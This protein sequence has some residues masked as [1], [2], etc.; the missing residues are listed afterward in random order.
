[1]KPRNLLILL[2]VV[3]ALAAFLWF[4]E[5][6]LPGS[7]E[8][9]EMA[10]RVLPG[11]ETGEVTALAVEVG[12]ERVR[13]E[14]R[15]DP[16]EKTDGEAGDDADEAADEAAADP[17]NAD[18]RFTAPQRFADRRAD[19][20]A[21]ADLL[22]A[23]AGL[24]RERTIDEVEPAAVGLDAPRARV[25]LEGTG[26]DPITLLVGG[27]VPA[28]S[29]MI[30]GRET[31][32]GAVAA[33]ASVVPRAIF[34]DLD[35]SAG[36]WRARDLFPAARSAVE[37]I[38]LTAAERPDDVVLERRDGESF[39]LVEPLND[40]ADPETV[41][42]L[43]TALTGLTAERFLDDVTGDDLAGLGLAPPRGSVRVDTAG[44]GEPFVLEVGAPTASDT[45]H[46]RLDGQVVT[47]R[48]ALL[49]AVERPAAEWPSRELTTL[50][51]YEIG[52][53]TVEDGAG[54][55][56]LERAT[57]DW[58]RDGARISYTAVS[59]LLYALTDAR[60]EETVPRGEAATGAP[61]VTFTLAATARDDGE[62]MGED[63][64]EDAEPPAAA[65]ETVALHPPLDDGRVPATVGGRDRVLLLSAD[66]AAEIA[67]ALAAVRAAEALPEEEADDGAGD[68]LPEG[69]EV[70]V[71]EGP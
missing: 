13:L 45:L 9:E 37:R 10:N 47:A 22:S 65:P 57:P 54:T 1:M 6:D 33:Q 64:D 31:A 49:E 15:A 34:T 12:E 30:V 35:L 43:L 58:R 17:R 18:W 20:A 4:V 61:E 14:R 28:S 42:A 11:L 5:R 70:E 67:D 66:T 36:E 8:R 60:A 48:A 53:V 41:D 27:E 2:L 56:H 71:E 40:R 68:D 38:V 19:A 16:A 21:V 52:E 25:T 7:E 24:T 3:L 69:V 44:G 39:E 59:D 55:L 26:D 62:E 50:R 32:D 23:L 46:L 29:N 51:V 63:G